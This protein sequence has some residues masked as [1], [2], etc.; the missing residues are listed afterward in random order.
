MKIAYITI[1]DPFNYSSWSGLNYNIYKC[2]KLQGHKITCIGPLKQDLKIFYVAKRIFLNLFGIKFDA[3]RPINLSKNYSK[4]VE[5]KIKGKNFDL[6]ITS[7]TNSVSF[8][9]TKIPIIVW[10]DTTFKSWYNHYFSGKKIFKNSIFEGD[11]C[12]QRTIKK[13]SKIILT[14][15][16]AM[17]DLLKYYKCSK[18]KINILPFGS[19][20]E[21]VPS[22]SKIKKKNYKKNKCRLISI[23][24][25]WN[26]KGFDRTINI[27]KNIIS[28]GLDVELH[29]V[30]PYK[31][32]KYNLPSWIKVSNFLNKNN[33]NNHKLIS[34]YLMNSDFH[35]LMTKAEACGVVFAEASS[36]G[37][38]SIAPKIGGIEGMIK[39][40][41]NG[42]LFS[43]N[44]SDKDIANYIFKVYK[45]KNKF[46]KLVS[47]SRKYYETHLNWKS[48]G[49]NLNKLLKGVINLEKNKKNSFSKN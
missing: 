25:D 2:L 34:K 44:F 37:L 19:N 10:L 49:F 39:N 5:K 8:L 31:A 32:K 46:K 27:C 36:H 22:F 7:D 9:D 21:V 3:D 33:K 29:I 43:N 17:N 23:G 11:Y 15:K 48:I 42:K 6:I 40:N 45:N 4:Q 24:V 20:L 35:I 16:W 18:R 28:K 47:S 13:S 30:G 38:Y 26:R 12:E 14:S 41:L 1:R